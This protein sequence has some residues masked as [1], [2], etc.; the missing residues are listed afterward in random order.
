MGKRIDPGKRRRFVTERV[1][2]GED[3]W[4]GGPDDHT[5]AG[6]GDG[7]GFLRP[8]RGGQDHIRIIRSLGKENILHNQMVEARERAAVSRETIEASGAVELADVLRRHWGLNPLDVVS[9]L[10]EAPRD[11]TSRILTSMLSGPIDVD[12]MDYLAR[13]S[14]HAGVPYGRHFD[15]D[16]LLASHREGQSRLNAYLDDYA[17]FARGLLDLYETCFEPRFFRAADRLASK[18]VWPAGMTTPGAAGH[19]TGG[20][21]AGPANAARLAVKKELGDRATVQLFSATKRDGEREAREQ[22]DR[23]LAT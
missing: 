3:L 1:D 4:T 7:A 18:G 2:K 11:R 14:L 10:S 22:L 17:F 6:V 23:F 15:Q 5:F 20:R 19:G 9:L 21:G 16:R 13:D 8:R 12:K